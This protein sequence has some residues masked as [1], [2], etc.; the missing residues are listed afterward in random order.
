MGYGTYNAH[1]KGKGK[2]GRGG[3]GPDNSDILS[4]SY[5]PRAIPMVEFEDCIWN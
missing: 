5:E 1:G 2:D 3:A 4:G